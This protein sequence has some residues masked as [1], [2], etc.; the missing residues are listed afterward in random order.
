MTVFIIQNPSAVDHTLGLMKP[1]YDFTPA[2]KF[3]DLVYLLSPVAVPNRP[4]EVIE[5]LQEKL[6]N[7]SDKDHLLLVGNPCFIGWSC[8]VAAGFNNGRVKMLQ[9]NGRRKRYY[10]V[11]ARG[12]I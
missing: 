5:Q 8:S 11:M 10:E 2:E 1:K 4:Q 12:L 6:S 3:G 9:W 7:F